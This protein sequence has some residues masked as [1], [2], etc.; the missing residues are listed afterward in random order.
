[1]K[2]PWIF[3]LAACTAL[4]LPAA[5][6]NVYDAEINREIPDD[7]AAGVISTIEVPEIPLEFVQY[8]NV[9]VTLEISPGDTAFTG[10]LYAYLQ[11]G[12]AI[13][14]LMN[15][16]GRTSTRQFGYDDNIAISLTF[17]D[18]GQFGDIHNYRLTLNGD[19]FVP[20]TSPLGGRWQPDGRATDPDEVVESD[21]R[22]LTL[23]NFA[24]SDPSGDWTI[25]FSDLSSGGSYTLKEWSIT[26]ATIPEPSTWALL[27]T[28][29]AILLT[30][31][32]KPR[33]RP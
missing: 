33:R 17:A 15:R 26:I 18:D 27:A 16:P 5:E 23:S 12:D 32:F 13:A 22:T 11:H 24:G 25:Y 14:V 19:D 28:G 31:R 7:S 6:T 29:F 4:H 9:S 2:G 10:D 20:V 21:P 30:A 3:L 8:I 1:M